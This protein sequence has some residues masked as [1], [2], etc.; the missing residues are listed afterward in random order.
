MA[1]DNTQQ[2]QDPAAQAA[3]PAA[4]PSTPAPAP[5]V[6]QQQAES[7]TPTPIEQAATPQTPE[8]PAPEAAQPVQPETPATP[9]APTPE[10]PAPATP[11]P[12]PVQTPTPTTPP[13]TASEAPTLATSTAPFPATPAAPKP[14]PAE[15]TTEPQTPTIEPLIKKEECK[16]T[17]I[18]VTEWD[19]QKRTLNKTFIK[20][21]SPRAF[22]V[23]ISFAIDV[24]RAKIAAEKKG[25]TIPEGAMIVDTGGMLW[26]TL[27]LEVEGAN[28]EDPSIV[29]LE[30]KEFYTKASSRPWKEMKMDMDEL[31]KELGH[32]P[33]EL[34]IWYVACPKCK[35]KKEI[36]TIYFAI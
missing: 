22:Y 24:N 14:T 33:K 25:Y 27:M 11:T 31:E 5:E 6:P 12:A 20:T 10:Q 9:A 15:T 3:Q 2:P 29:S 7:A 18:E 17:K 26:A 35:D 8:V 13:P 36:K 30:G 21:F 23:P 28:T 32:K 19:K 4:T 34:Y 1:Q 16:C